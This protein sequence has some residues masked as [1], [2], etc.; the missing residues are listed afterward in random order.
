MDYAT[1]ELFVP[2]IPAPK[3]VG[4]P[5]RDSYGYRH[6]QAFRELCGLK[7]NPYFREP[8]QGAVRL[9]CYFWLPTPSS[10][11]PRKVDEALKGHIAPT[12]KP[13]LKNLVAGVE[14]ALN[15][16]AWL[17]DAQVTEYGH[18]TKRYRRD[19]EIGTKICIELL[20]GGE[21]HR[22]TDKAYGRE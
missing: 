10:W 11:A 9:S 3:P 15:R 17:D 21:A 4:P 2:G 14:D 16:I 18:C 22:L 6:Y 7:A 20:D 1:I 8:L 19:D 12:S 13:D 5:K